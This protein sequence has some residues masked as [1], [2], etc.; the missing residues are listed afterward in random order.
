VP[1]R[2]VTAGANWLGC[3]QL[4]A[5]ASNG[6]SGGWRVLA[7][8]VGLRE[9][10][11]DPMVQGAPHAL[12]PHGCDVGVDHRRVEL[13]AQHLRLEKEQGAEGLV[14]GRGADPRGGRWGRPWWDHSRGTKVG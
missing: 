12:A 13:A 3:L 14:L 9:G 10:W 7:N 8:R 1:A 4:V 5:V 2:R 11:Q 6:P